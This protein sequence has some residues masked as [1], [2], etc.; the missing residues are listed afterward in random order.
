MRV[1]L[2]KD[3]K[4]VGRQGE[5]R[6]V[7]D[8][9]A[10]NFLVP[11]NLAIPYDKTGIAVKHTLDVREEHTQ[12]AIK[13]TLDYLANETIE[14]RLKTGGH[15]ELF[16]GVTSDMIKRELEGRGFKNIHPILPK[17]IKALGEYRVE[18]SVGRNLKGTVT[19]KVLSQS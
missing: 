9:Y 10:R 1:L 15:G 18:V 7:R 12:G 17:P 4:G 13:K 16:Q 5:V 3:V 19:L 2:T 8:G 6:D 11:R 14:Y